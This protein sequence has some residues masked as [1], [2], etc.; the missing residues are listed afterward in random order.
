[1]APARES[2]TANV[3]LAHAV[4]NGTR[5]AGD[6]EF[7]YYLAFTHGRLGRK[8]KAKKLLRKVLALDPKHA[9]ARSVLS[10]LSG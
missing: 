5:P 3:L 1:M 9:D 7:L 2:Q 10:F 8:A 4:A 6:A